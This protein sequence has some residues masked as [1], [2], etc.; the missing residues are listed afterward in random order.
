MHDQLATN[1][2]FGFSSQCMVTII[3]PILCFETAPC[4]I[5]KVDS[6]EEWSGV[7]LEQIERISENPV[8]GEEVLLM[9]VRSIEILADEAI[10]GYSEQV[11]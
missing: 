6:V 3:L 4:Y 8:Q 10:A 7:L 11:G 5:P 2:E 9:T 1:I